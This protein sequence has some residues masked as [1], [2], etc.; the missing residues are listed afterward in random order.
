MPTTTTTPA[1]RLVDLLDAIDQRG[2]FEVAAD[3]GQPNRDLAHAYLLGHL[4]AAAR[5]VLTPPA[6][7]R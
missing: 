1:G 5:D 6:N 7:H 4:I 3:L 2:A